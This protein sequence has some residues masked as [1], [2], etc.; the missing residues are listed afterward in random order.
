LLDTYEGIPDVEG[1][2]E[3]ES[4]KREHLNAKC[5]SDSSE[6]ARNKF[7]DCSNVEIARGFLP[8]TLVAVEGRKIAHL[9]VD[10]NNAPY[11]QAVIQRL[12]PQLVPGAFVVMDDYAF[13]GHQ[14]QYDMWNAF[15]ARHKL[16]IATLPTGQGLLM[17]PRG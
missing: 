4:S 13:K 14:A 2:S 5:Y 12:W 3:Y 6:F 7:K 17:K 11:E 9:S 16:L 8:D 10:L 1:M 15:V